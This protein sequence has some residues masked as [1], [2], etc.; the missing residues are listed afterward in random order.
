MN[1]HGFVSGT[2][3]SGKSVTLRLIAEELSKQGIP[4]LVTDI[5]GDLGSIGEK[6]E[7]PSEKIE[8]WKARTFPTQKWDVFGIEGKPLNA[9]VEEVGDLLLGRMLDLNPTQTGVLSVVF[10][11]AAELGKSVKTL[12]H[13]M[14]A[15]DYL[16]SKTYKMTAKR[17][18]HISPASAGVVQR[19]IFELKRHGGNSFFG[20]TAISLDSF[21][22]TKKEQ[23]VINILEARQLVQFPTLYAAVMAWV[24]TK[25][26]NELP[27]VGNLDKPKF[28]VFIDEAH[29]LFEGVDKR[30]L[31]KIE[32]CIKLIRSKGVGI[33]LITQS[34]SDI[35]DPILSQLGN[36]I[37]HSL[38]SF[39]PREN[40]SVKAIADSFVPNLS[41]DTE[42]EIKTLGVGEALVSFLDE[43]GK[44]QPVEKVK[45]R[46]PQS[47][48]T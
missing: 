12:E 6:A 21:L 46:L 33:F 24:L 1:R 4:C 25:L 13:I 2:T 16:T 15:I 32:Q 42:R 43:C 18:Q 29:L 40:R 23:G 34:P 41:I 45:I 9:T 39:T 31:K 5:K 14:E 37:Q 28:I 30:L 48:I 27:E 11:L 36:R 17:V 3:G 19:K 8:G 10:D 47:R 7:K 38:Y 35:P 44:P 20:N 22:K 26:Y